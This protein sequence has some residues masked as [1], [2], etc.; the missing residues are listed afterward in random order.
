MEFMVISIII[1]YLFSTTGYVIYLLAQKDYLQKAAFYCL[2]AG[3]ILHCIAMG[4]E[5]ACYYAHITRTMPVHNL[6]DTLSVASWSIAGVFLLL[7][8]K[9]RLKV[10]GVFAA[11]LSATVMIIA[12]WLPDI[13]V[14]VNTAFNSL[15]V[16]VHVVF[17]FI[18]EASM[19]LAFAT[20]L[21]YL[22]QEHAIKTKKRGFFYKRLPSLDLL[23]TTGYVC[24]VVGFSMLTIGLIL[25][26]VY[27]KLIS[28]NFWSWT[29][30][31]VFS[32][33]T[34]IVYAGLI[35]QRFTVGWRGRRAAIMAI[36]GFIIVL[37]TFFG[38][39][40]LLDIHHGDFMQVIK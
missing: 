17:I 16:V 9:F 1:L 25:G 32:G 30:K 15:W 34:W 35:H 14:E 10:L 40:F 12:N 4:Y 24:I 28:D 11:S 38:V 26:I 2:F 8:Y 36:I 7:R 33:I 23:D 19:A 21:L 3:F 27:A 5:Y 18:G 22:V 6:H 37:F 13:P 39:N 29:L 31:E 20:G